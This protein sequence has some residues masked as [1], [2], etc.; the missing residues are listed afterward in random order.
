VDSFGTLSLFYYAT[1]AALSLTPFKV[2]FPLCSLRFQ[3]T[4]ISG[5][6]L[7]PFCLK[8]VVSLFLPCLPL[9]PYMCWPLAGFLLVKVEVL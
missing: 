3:V 7:L 8:I 5:A 6:L 4:A 9:Y 1:W 2:Y